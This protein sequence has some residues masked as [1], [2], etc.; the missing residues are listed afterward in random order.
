MGPEG[1]LSRRDLFNVEAVHRMYTI[2]FG[3]R[4][5]VGGKHC[6]SVVLGYRCFVDLFISFDPQIGLS[7]HSFLAA[8]KNITNLCLACQTPFLFS[9]YLC[10]N[11]KVAI[12]RFLEEPRE[13]SP[14]CHTGL[15]RHGGRPDRKNI[16]VFLIRKFKLF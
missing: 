2:S 14:R 3:S 10:T 1:K 7:W 8:V 16:F 5:L 6:L 4:D 11:Q 9:Q 15:G 12:L 13:R